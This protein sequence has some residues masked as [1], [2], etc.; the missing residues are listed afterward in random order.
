M[1]VNKITAFWYRLTLEY[2]PHER[3]EELPMGIQ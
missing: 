3:T 2:L 1:S